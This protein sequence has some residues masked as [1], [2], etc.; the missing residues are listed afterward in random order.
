[1]QI[2]IGI[3]AMGGYRR[4]NY[5]W[6]YAF[7]ELVDNATQSYF[8][9]RAALEQ[10]YAIEQSQ[11]TVRITTDAH[12]IRVH[13]NAMGMNY[14]DL[15]RALQIGRQPTVST[16]RCRYGLGLKT[17][18]S[19]MGNQ[20]V[21]S[22]TKL[23]EEEEFTVLVDVDAIIAGNPNLVVSTR[24]VPKDA[25]YT[26]IVVK[27]LNRTIASR[28]KD[29]AKKFLGSIYR[30]DIESSDLHL[31]LDGNPISWERFLEDRF[32]R[33]SDGS[34]VKKKF[35]NVIVNCSSGPKV[36]SGWVGVV[37]EGSRTIAGF[38]M[39][40]KDRVLRGFPENW[41]PAEIFGDGG[42]NDLINQR[43][44]GEINLD[45]FE[46][47]H[48]KD[49]INW[50][51]DEEERVE[52]ALLAQCQDYME[53]ARGHRK[54]KG[55][56]GPSEMA[57]KIAV[58]TLE[59]ELQSQAFVDRFQ[60]Q[61]ILPS[62]D[63]VERNRHLT[64]AK[65]EE[66]SRPNIE[67]LVGGILNVKVFVDSN[68]SQRDYYFDVESKSEFEVLVVINMLH[69]HWQML[70]TDEAVLNYFRHCIYDGIARH[71]TRHNPTA[72][73]IRHVKDEYLR[74]GFDILQTPTSP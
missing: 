57:V 41:R 2:G 33:L 40:Q 44:V 9:N 35:E 67:I 46:P 34:L 5:E 48:T 62:Q 58:N 14:Q 71:V 8:D 10:Q 61:T 47:T 49:N 51:G 32:L 13:D 25:H 38:A 60:H 63:E 15:E 24:T 23:G 21:I 12:E 1:M 7:A 19:W 18:A 22:T 52:K 53:V 39:M 74:V 69:P 70:S 50:S 20:W 27:N 43:L 31:E 28:T 17:S 42:R 29:K 45:G 56:S 30:R 4:L 72:D 65:M 55:S 37:A 64:F 11:L 68:L 26:N 54:G 66:I 59:K 16:G 3:G 6:W 73:R 36:I